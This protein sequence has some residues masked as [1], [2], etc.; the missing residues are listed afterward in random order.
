MAR[1]LI[2]SSPADLLAEVRASL[3]DAGHKVNTTESADAVLR[4][5]RASSVDLVIVADDLKGGTGAEVCEALDGVSPRSKL[6]YVGED[7]G[8]RADARVAPGESFAV[9]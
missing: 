6:L 4:A 5:A 3:E 9:L 1:V 2:G 8:A 7:A